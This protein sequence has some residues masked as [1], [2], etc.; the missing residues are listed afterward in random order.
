MTLISRVANCLAAG[1]KVL[2]CSQLVRRGFIALN[3]RAAC[4]PQMTVVTRHKCRGIEQSG[5]CSRVLYR[6]L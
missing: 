1:N 4:Y 3:D 6:L 2:E 5:N